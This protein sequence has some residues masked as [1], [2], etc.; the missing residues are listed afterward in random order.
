MHSYI[1]DAARFDEIFSNTDADAI[2]AAWGDDPKT[3]ATITHRLGAYNKAQ[4]LFVSEYGGI[5]WDVKSGN[6]DAWGYGDA[7]K[8]EQEFI[9]RYRNLTTTLLQNPSMFGF[10]YTQLYDTEQEVNGLYNYDRTP[11]F[12]MSVF[13]EI[14]RQKAAIE[15]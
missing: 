2:L 4:P 9:E 14:N 7:P 1:Q 15:D 5:K 3:H 8:T 6:A 10:C 13:Y 11:K 12:D